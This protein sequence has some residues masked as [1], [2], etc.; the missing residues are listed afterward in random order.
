MEAI[1]EA[2][3]AGST[4]RLTSPTDTKEAS[5]WSE[6]SWSSGE[7]FLAS[8]KHVFV[9]ESK[10]AVKR[11][12]AV[13]AAWL[14]CWKQTCKASSS[15]ELDAIHPKMRGIT[16]APNLAAADCSSTFNSSKLGVFRTIET[17]V[18][19]VAMAA[20]TT[21]SVQVCMRVGDT[22]VDGTNAGNDGTAS[23][24]KA[25]GVR[26]ARFASSCIDTKSP[27]RSEASKKVKI[28]GRTSSTFAPTIVNVAHA[29]VTQ[30]PT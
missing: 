22:D 16:A 13:T 9:K 19:V 3:V 23:F 1:N 24:V 21:A 26:S 8:S 15:V 10:T 30:W 14:K 18:T 7:G 25:M 17:S 2:I 12:G 6:E 20:F 5:T 11:E 27:C 29:S 28:P 4:R